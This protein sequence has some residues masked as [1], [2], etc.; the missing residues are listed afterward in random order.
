MGYIIFHRDHGE[1]GDDGC[2]ADAVTPCRRCGVIVI[3]CSTVGVIGMPCAV[4]V[5][6]ICCTYLLVHPHG[7]GLEVC[8]REGGITW[9]DML[10]R[11]GGVVERAKVELEVEDAAGTNTG[12]EIIAQHSRDREGRLGSYDYKNYNNYNN[13]NTNL[14]SSML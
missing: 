4:C 8:S 10:D 2:A 1:P 9:G 11:C 12:G 14:T 7:E 13:Y 3:S 5:M 6:G